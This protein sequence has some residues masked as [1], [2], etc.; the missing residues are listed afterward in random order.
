MASFRAS[1]VKATGGWSP[2]NDAIAPEQKDVHRSGPG[3]ILGGQGLVSDGLD[4]DRPFPGYLAARLG[5]PR[6]LLEGGLEELDGLGEIPGLQGLPGLGCRREPLR[7]FLSAF[8]RCGL[9]E[10]ELRREAPKSS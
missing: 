10:R 6:I 7:Q 1:R 4:L 3:E 8:S 9:V 2:S 5:V